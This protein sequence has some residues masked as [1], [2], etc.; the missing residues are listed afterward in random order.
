MLRSRVDEVLRDNFGASPS[1]TSSHP[2]VILMWSRVDFRRPMLG[3]ASLLLAARADTLVW[4]H[5]RCRQASTLVS[6]MFSPNLAAQCSQ[7]NPLR[8]GG[9][10]PYCHPP[11]R[12]TRHRLCWILQSP[13]G[14]TW[15]FN[16][17]Y[18]TKVGGNHRKPGCLSRMWPTDTGPDRLASEGFRPWTQSQPLACPW[19]RVLRCSRTPRGCRNRL[20]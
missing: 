10:I 19:P 5:G 14:W 4:Q 1:P 6:N 15:A 12:G 11:A 18:M 7:R 17:I 2:R 13:W 20:A 16:W 3:N 8:K 9:Q